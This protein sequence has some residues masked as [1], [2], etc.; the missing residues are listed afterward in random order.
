MCEFCGK[1]CSSQKKEDRCYYTHYRKHKK[2]SHK[3]IR[4]GPK[5]DDG[6]VDMMITPFCRIGF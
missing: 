4:R 5:G 6:K 1:N 2:S 3:K